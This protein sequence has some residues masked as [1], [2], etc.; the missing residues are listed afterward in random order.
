M[1]SPETKKKNKGLLERLPKLGRVSQLVLIVG[2][3]LVLFIPLWIINQQQPAKQAQLETTLINLQRILGAEQT[4]KTEYEAEL[5]QAK[6]ETEAA[7]AVYPTPN[8]SP[9]ILATILDL[10]S[11]NDIYVIK[12]AVST[13]S[14]SLGTILTFSLGLEGQIPKFQ[15]FLLAL[16]EKLPTSQIKTVSFTVSQGGQ[17]YDAASIA[18]N[19]SCYSGKK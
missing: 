10:A 17:E 2:I 5:A 15:N 14:G 11:Q 8:Q 13:S 16:G 4:P 19:V 9:E 6:A 1:T 7:R 3:F 18:I 12:T